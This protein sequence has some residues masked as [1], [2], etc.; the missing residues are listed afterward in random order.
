MQNKYQLPPDVRRTV[1]GLVQGYNRRKRELLKSEEEICSVGSARY[2]TI[3]N[4]ESPEDDERVYLPLGKG[5]VS[6]P[7]ESQAFALMNLHNS[8]DY[9]CNRIIEKA[10]EEL[11]M[12]YYNK[13]LV[14]KIKK[15]L[16]LSCELG[17]KF[18]Y[19]Y[20]EIIGID[21]STFYRIRQHF[22][23]IVAQKFNFI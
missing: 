8:F 21:K 23:Y 1:I 7:V 12:Y 13:D 14:S 15:N 11:P 5:G 4:S 6:F 19:P 20:W 18:S 10:L 17:K 22:L 16:I 3:H 2:E 9:N